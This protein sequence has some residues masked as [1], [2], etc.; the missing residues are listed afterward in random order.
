MSKAPR[1]STRK[2]P[3]SHCAMV[4]DAA[5]TSVKPK[6]PAITA[7]IKKQRPTSAWTPPSQDPTHN[8]LDRGRVPSRDRRPGCARTGIARLPTS[9]IDTGQKIT[10]HPIEKIGLLQIH[11]MPR[12]WHHDGA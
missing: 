10:D 5:S 9:R 7:M 1:N 3:N 8:E 12:F 4:A 2:M 11:R 6:M